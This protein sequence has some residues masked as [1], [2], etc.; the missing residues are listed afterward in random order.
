VNSGKQQREWILLKGL[1]YF[2][3]I[4]ILP[5]ILWDILISKYMMPN[6]PPRL[7]LNR[8]MK[9]IEESP[10]Y[11]QPEHVALMKYYTEPQ[12]KQVNDPWLCTMWL[13]GLVPTPRSLPACVMQSWLYG[14]RTI[15]W[16]YSLCDPSYM[17]LNCNS[18]DPSVIWDSQ[19]DQLYR[20]SSCINTHWGLDGACALCWSGMLLGYTP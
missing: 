3:M 18:P 1:L 20:L 15:L 16:G 10:R 17:P 2:A 12:M 9:T 7:N 11:L 13:E 8:F 6:W 5:F 14:Q 4:N 19:L